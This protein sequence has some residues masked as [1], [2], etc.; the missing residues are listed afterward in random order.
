MGAPEEKILINGIQQKN[1]AV[2]EKLFKEY[3]S[4]LCAYSKLIVK[5]NDIAE[6]LVQELFFKIWNKGRDFSI[7]T[8]LKSYLYKA[9]YNNSIDYL[10]TLKNE[11]LYKEYNV[12]VLQNSDNGQPD[13]DMIA[14]IYNAID[15]LPEKCGEVFKLRKFENMSHA[16]ISKKLKISVKTVETH[17]HRANLAL[18]EKLK[19]L[20]ILKVPLI[21]FTLCKG[22]LMVI[23]H[24]HIR[25]L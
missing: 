15:E 1:E 14:A 7:S 2:F 24:I 9:T 17:M 22:F 25:S 3:Y 18:K 8:S 11:L 16:E 21:F 20:D 19:K 10:R 12:K 6:D 5:R 23:H 13:S 4:S